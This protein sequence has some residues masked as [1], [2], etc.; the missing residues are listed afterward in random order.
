MDTMDHGNISYYVIMYYI[1]IIINMEIFR[2]RERIKRSF[3]LSR[4]TI[5]LI[6]QIDECLPTYLDLYI[7]GLFCTDL[8]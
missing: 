8:L 7:H 2:K 3:C 4:N 1:K 6:S 5:V